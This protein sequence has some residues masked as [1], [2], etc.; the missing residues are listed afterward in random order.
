MGS[1]RVANSLFTLQSQVNSLCPGRNKSSDG[2]IGDAAHQAQ[3]SD[4][5]PDASGI[6]RALDLTHDPAHGF[7]IDAFT[8]ALQVGRDGRISYVI[9]NQLIMSGNRGPLPWVWQ[10]YDG[11]DP[12]TGHVHISVIDSLVADNTTPWDLSAWKKEA[13][14]TPEQARLLANV[15]RILTCWSDGRL[16]Y[17]IDYGSGGDPLTLPNPFIELTEVIKELK[18]L[19]VAGQQMP[20]LDYQALVKELLLQLA[21]KPSTEG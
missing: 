12:H 15:E 11:D 17:G 21:S 8:D 16:P 10:D 3:V 20:P 2:T 7:D 5:N 18:G 13:E 14:V 19:V 6:V 9:A 1:W 4:H